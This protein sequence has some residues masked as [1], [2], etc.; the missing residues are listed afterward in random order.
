MISLHNI[1]CVEFYREFVFIDKFLFWK[2]EYESEINNLMLTC[3]MKDIREM[4]FSEKI[5]IESYIRGWHFFRMILWPLAFYPLT[6]RLK[7]ITNIK[8]RG[9]ISWKIR[10]KLIGREENNEVRTSE[11]NEVMANEIIW[12]GNVLPVFQSGLGIVNFRGKY[13]NALTGINE[14]I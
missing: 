4:I 5:L 6:G 10:F 2:I 1:V 13:S 9:M 14:M 3:D 12:N 7:G 11:N 8:F